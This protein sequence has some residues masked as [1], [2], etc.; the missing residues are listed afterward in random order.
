MKTP[1]PM[2]GVFISYRREDSPGHAGR[3]FDRVRAKFGGD[4]VFM[5][6][7]AIDAG[8]DFVDAI[9]QAVGTCDV[10][11]AIIG[12]QWSSAADSAGRRRLDSATDFVRLEIAGALKR[13]VRV[14]PVLVDGAQL[15]T[16][17]DL[18]EDLQPLLRRNAIELRDARWD[19]DIDQLLASL[20]RIVKRPPEALRL[21]KPA[22]R[23]RVLA[24]V[25]VVAV[26]VGA[27]AIFAPR[28][29]APARDVTSSALT[30]PAAA[31]ATAATPTAA[32]PPSITATPQPPT[33]TQPSPAAAQPS[34][35]GSASPSS[36][37]PKAAS[38]PDVVGRTLPDAREILRRAGVS[39]ARV[40][41]RDDRTKA[42]D[43]VVVQTDVRTSASAP[44]AVTL[45]A[46]ARAAVVIHH[47]AEDAA[48]A[49]TLLGTLIAIPATADIAFRTM[50]LAA[51]R[52]ETVSRVTYS[53]SDLTDV[54]VEI[55]KTATAWLRRNEPERKGF[56]AMRNP[57]VAART[58]V[59]GLPARDSP[60]AA[61]DALP[62][63]RGKSVGEARR[64]LTAAGVALVQTKWV[65]GDGRQ[66]GLV[67]DQ[68][69]GR[70]PSGQRSVVLDA[71]ARGIVFLYHSAAD[72]AMADRLARAL[73]PRTEALGILVNLLQVRTT[74]SPELRG[75]VSTNGTALI[76][77]ARTVASLASDWLTKEV[78]RA[79]PIEATDNGTMGPQR[80]VL[81]FRSL[82]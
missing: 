60:T 65:E 4:I 55:A 81:G 22:T 73:R 79:V 31:T 63:V 29:C 64:T 82:P 62:N 7:T 66:P 25:A 58:I 48:V 71:G 1:A 35:T 52:A 9:D 59:I 15:P 61:L 56:T 46:V 24:G 16:A 3:V 5:D 43:V 49:R 12:P 77:E 28:G 21:E 45:T 40:L 47:R 69:E 76:R 74:V 78:G 18:S 10:L 33:V 53:D 14:V 6:V 20:E 36:P 54:G 30:T 19:V 13:N 32:T 75:T 44:P 39:V 11:L 68:I 50:E 26:T 34:A 17:S 51:I 72:A 38:V 8:A 23:V 27:A 57:S 67:F 80:L 70:L 2:A 41:Y 37:P 42:V